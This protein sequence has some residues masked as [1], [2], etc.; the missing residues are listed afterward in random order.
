LKITGDPRLV[1]A[2]TGAVEHFAQ[3][4]GLDDASQKQL[5][6][7]AEQACLEVFTQ[8]ESPESPVDVSIDHHADRLEILIAHVTDQAPA[9]GLDSFFSTDENAG[10]THG[11]LLMT[12]VDRVLY[13]SEGGKSRLRLVK[14]LNPGAKRVQ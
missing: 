2:V 1:G 7:A 11:M 8:L 14:Y 9:I 10:P 3:E 12:L 5:M 6:S 13:D 4:A